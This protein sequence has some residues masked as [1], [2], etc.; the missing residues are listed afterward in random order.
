MTHAPLDAFIAAVVEYGVTDICIGAGS[1]S[2]AILQALNKQPVT[3]HPFLDERAV[4]FL[5]LGI[6]KATQRPVMIVTTSGSAVTNVL[7][8]IT[9]AAHSFHNLIICTADRPQRL[10]GTCANQTINQV[11]IF[12]NALAELQ[13][14]E[15]QDN[16]SVFLEDLKQS[17]IKQRSVGGPIHINC[18]L[19]D[20]VL[21]PYQASDSVV[22]MGIPEPSMQPNEQ[23]I[24]VVSNGVLSATNGWVCVGQLEP[25]V[26]REDIES[27]VKSWVG[28]PLWMAPIM[29]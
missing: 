8:A 13:L 3:I 7:P 20:P 11:G 14:P 21:H 27:F 22:K 18:P 6:T 25:W 24:A 19:E 4:G 1:R 9:E 23:K 28:Q 29:A 15:S 26:N 10:R 16:Q 17:F 2:S 12:N 5:A